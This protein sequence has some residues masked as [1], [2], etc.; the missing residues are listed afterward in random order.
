MD[1]NYA[2]PRGSREGHA[3][4]ASSSGMVRVL[5]GGFVAAVLLQLAMLYLHV[6]TPSGAA[7]IPHADKIVHAAIFAAPAL[8]G[9]LAGLRAWVVALVLGLHAPVSE[10]VQHYVLAGRQGDPMDMFA[11][12]VGIALGT[13]VAL[14]L[15]RRAGFPG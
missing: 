12:W 11:D 1:T 15:T 8:L 4:A 6:P 7:S 2:A 3:A 9:V 5:R 13:G 10:L 14:W